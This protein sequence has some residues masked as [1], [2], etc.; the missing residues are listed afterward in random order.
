[1]KKIPAATAQPEFMAIYSLNPLQ[2]IK[3]SRLFFPVI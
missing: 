1:M 2:A 3:Y